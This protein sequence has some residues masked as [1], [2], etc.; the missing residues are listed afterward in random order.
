MG[1]G[2]GGLATVVMQV[3][4]ARARIK[5]GAEGVFCGALPGL[6]YGIALKIDDGAGRGAEIAMGGILERLGIFGPAERERLE[7]VLRPVIKNMAGRIVGSIR[8]AATLVG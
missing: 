5:P 8:P 1:D 3:A 6:G 4:G 2:T 7:P